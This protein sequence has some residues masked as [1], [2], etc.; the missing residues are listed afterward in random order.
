VSN[1]A[2]HHYY[3]FKGMILAD[4]HYHLFPGEAEALD[5]FAE[6]NWHQLDGELRLEFTDAPA[7][8]I[9]WGRGGSLGDGAVRYAVNVRDESFFDAYLLASL[10][11][12]DHPYWSNLIGHD[13]RLDYMDPEHQILRI[14]CTAGKLFLSSQS[15]DGRFQGDSLRISPLPPQGRRVTPESSP[16]VLRRS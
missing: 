8:F 6:R 2:Q 16:L 14:A 10:E 7:C 15:V 9:S 13:L 12:S 1:Y 11:M 5:A 4:I 3:N